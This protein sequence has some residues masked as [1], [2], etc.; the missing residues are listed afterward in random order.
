MQAVI[1]CT[2]GFNRSQH[3]PTSKLVRYTSGSYSDARELEKPA[4]PELHVLLGEHLSLRRSGVDEV[5][6]TSVHYK[7]CLQYHDTVQC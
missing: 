1:H 6:K 5:A 2:G 4:P 3:S 7:W